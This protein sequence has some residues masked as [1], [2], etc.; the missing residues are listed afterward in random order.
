MRRCGHER[1]GFLRAET[2]AVEHRQPLAEPILLYREPALRQEPGERRGLK[3][4]HRELL[5]PIHAEVQ[6]GIGLHLEIEHS[7]PAP[8]HH[9]LA[10]HRRE[11]GWQRIGHQDRARFG[12]SAQDR[13]NQGVGVIGRLDDD[14]RLAGVSARQQL[15]NRHQQRRARTARRHA[16]SR[17]RGK[18]MRLV[19]RRDVSR[20]I[21]RA[22]EQGRS[23]ECG[24]KQEMD[25]SAFDPHR[26]DRSQR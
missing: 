9:P 26:R 23:A 14:H 6:S 3:V 10:N 15:Q 24:M 17:Q 13:G 18:D 11:K 8:P 19:E 22:R 4:G 16:R 5:A 7:P 12:K 21:Q 2:I 20:P 25:R 1:A